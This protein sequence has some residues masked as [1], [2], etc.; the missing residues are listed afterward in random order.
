MD[1]TSANV[2]EQAKQPKHEQD[3]N[4]CP[5]HGIIPFRFSLRLIGIYPE[6]YFFAKLFRN[7]LE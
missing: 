4:Y 6:D 3:D 7:D 5:Q 1:Q 2:A